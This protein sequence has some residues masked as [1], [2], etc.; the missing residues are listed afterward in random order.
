MRAWFACT[1]AELLVREP[2]DTL[3]R[4]AAA[5]ADRGLAAGVEQIASSARAVAA[6]RAAVQANDGTGWT[7]AREYALIRLQKRIDAVILVLEFKARAPDQTAPR[8]VEAYALDLSDF[9]EASRA[10]PIVPVLVAGEAID[11]LPALCHGG[12]TASGRR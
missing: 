1:G 10:N 3:G 5:Q 9:H 4:L 8:Q 7:I 2:E 6:L 12:R 11:P